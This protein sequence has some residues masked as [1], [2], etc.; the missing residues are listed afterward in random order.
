[1]RRINKE[2]SPGVICLYSEAQKCAFSCKNSLIKCAERKITRSFF[3]ISIDFSIGYRY[4]SSEG[5][6]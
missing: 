4:N 3:V 5:G 1:M 2:I 6:G